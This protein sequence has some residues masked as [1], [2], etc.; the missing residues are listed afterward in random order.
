MEQEAKSVVFKG[1]SDGLVI[2][3]PEGCE[4]E[5]AL[6]EIDNKVSNAARFFKGAK[7]KV[8]YRGMNLT[9]DQ[10]KAVYDI[11]V[12][13]SGAVV[14]SFSRDE[15][16]KGAGNIAPKASRASEATRLRFYPGIDEG[17][18]KFVKNTVRSGTRIDYDGNVVIIGDVNPG[19]E[20]V[21]TGNVVVL[22]TVRGMVH[23]G[24]D[25]NRDAFVFALGLK[26][27]QIRIAESIARMPEESE[28]DG[29]CPELATVKD[30]VI[31]VE[32]IMRPTLK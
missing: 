25:G 3:F 7:I 2:V 4:F 30:G 21:A 6:Q 13:K 18:C 16:N 9:T 19:A 23:A 27:T 15:E 24:A 11:L 29:F 31:V 14:E 22:G 12:K 26:P 17:N 28:S 8:V 10:E 32:Q 20:V 1:N 5:Q